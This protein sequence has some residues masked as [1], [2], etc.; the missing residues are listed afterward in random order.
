MKQV[1]EDPTKANLVVH[2]FCWSVSQLGYG[3]Y[4]A[5][6]LLQ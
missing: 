5:P 3:A 6:S 1:L 4:P 2:L